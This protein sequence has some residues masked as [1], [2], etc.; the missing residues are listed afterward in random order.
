VRATLP[1]LC[2]ARCR[3]AQAGRCVGGWEVNRNGNLL[4]AASQRRLRPSGERVEAGQEGAG[5]LF[6]V[7]VPAAAA[8]VA[9]MLAAEVVFGADPDRCLFARPSWE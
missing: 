6:V 3:R 9:D 7:A 4:P 2:V 1:G 5:D 8:E